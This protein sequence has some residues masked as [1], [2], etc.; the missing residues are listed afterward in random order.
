[1]GL[2]GGECGEVVSDIL[3]RGRLVCVLKYLLGSSVDICGVDELSQA[4]IV[5]VFDG[6]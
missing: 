5:Q 6:H 1:M 4:V 2:G 3:L